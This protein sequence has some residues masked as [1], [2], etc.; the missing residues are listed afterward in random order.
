MHK[1]QNL[2]QNAKYLGGT[3]KKS[4]Y[5]QNGPKSKR[6]QVRTASIWSKRPHKLVKTAPHT[7]NEGQ[8]GPKSKRFHFFFFF[9][10]VNA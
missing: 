1:N 3:P 8:N 10:F 5:S 6:P 9:F 7:K 2:S 4:N